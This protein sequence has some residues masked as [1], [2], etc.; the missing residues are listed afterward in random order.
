MARQHVFPVCGPSGRT[1]V[2]RNKKD[3][4]RFKGD[5]A[6]YSETEDK[7]TFYFE[8][9][10]TDKF[11][12]NVFWMRKDQHSYLVDL[13]SAPDTDQTF[14]PSRPVLML[15]PWADKGLYSEF[16]LWEEINGK[17]RES[18]LPDPGSIFCI[19]LKGNVESSWTHISFIAAVIN[20]GNN[21][22]NRL[23]FSDGIYISNLDRAEPEG[24]EWVTFMWTGTR[25]VFL[26]S[27][28]WV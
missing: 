6:R 19:G 25:F 7:D 11:L 20:F 18:E 10:N 15:F 27:N 13:T 24:L 3:G 12:W 16:L 5:V 2:P 1:F 14:D 4:G 26:G 22:E 23:P 9:T 21:S 8:N 28:N 17:I